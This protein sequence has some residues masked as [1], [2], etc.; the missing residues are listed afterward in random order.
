MLY[1]IPF[2]LVGSIAVAVLWPRRKTVKAV[3]NFRSQPS[4]EFI[5]AW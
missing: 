5:A 2:M 3:P 1:L 4:E